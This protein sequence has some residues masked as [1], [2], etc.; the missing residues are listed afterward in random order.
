MDHHHAG[1]DSPFVRIQNLDMVF[2]FPLDYLHLV[3]L[4]VMRK[5]LKIWVSGLATSPFSIDARGKRLINRRLRRIRKHLCSEFERRSVSL[6]HLGTWKGQEFRT[7]LLYTGIL[8]FI[9]FIFNKSTSIIIIIII[10]IFIIIINRSISLKE[11]F[12]RRKI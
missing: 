12:E 5:K 6:D 9:Q 4:G 1:G 3:L 10:T 8:I 7:F 2:G 11:R